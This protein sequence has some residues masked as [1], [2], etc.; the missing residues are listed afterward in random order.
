[1][2]SIII[3]TLDRAVGEDAG[4]LAQL[5][6]MTKCE[7][8]VS[9]DVTRQGFTKTV[10]E[11]IRRAHKSHDIC[12][13]NDDIRWYAYGWLW[14]LRRALYADKRFGMVAPSGPSNTAPLAHGKI[15]DSGLQPV[16]HIAFWC[17]LI[18]RQ[19]L[20]D[21][22]LLD[23]AYIH[24]ASDNQFSDDATRKG[25]KSIWCK[26]VYLHHRKHGSGSRNKWKKH[27]QALYRRRRAAHR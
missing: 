4:R 25:W 1:M 8:I 24:F 22:G 15:G 12:L 14:T 2:I 3:P 20:N 10:N 21:V 6:A 5:T 7:V 9:H 19:C 17:V 16:K 13:L 27:D 11:G 26:D 23:E 18:K